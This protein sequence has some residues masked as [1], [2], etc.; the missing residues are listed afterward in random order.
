[1]EEL[2]LG[3]MEKIRAISE[4]IVSALKAIWEDVGLEFGVEIEVV[5]KPVIKLFAGIYKYRKL[6]KREERNGEHGNREKRNKSLQNH[7]EGSS[8]RNST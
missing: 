3:T 6:M 2:P 1:M 4:R 8:K 5:P 7:D